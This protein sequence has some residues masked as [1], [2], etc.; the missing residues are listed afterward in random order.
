MKTKIYVG[1]VFDLGP[2]RGH[3][4]LFEQAKK[5][6]DYVIV[7][8]NSDSFT[9]QYKKKRPVQDQFE[10][11]NAVMSCRYVDMAFIMERGEDQIHYISMISPN[12]ILHGEGWERDSLIKQLG[13]TKEFMAENNIELRYVPLIPEIS[14]TKIKEKVK[15]Q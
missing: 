2:H 5:M 14:S 12:Y 1:G 4:Y 15:L 10:R 7:A 3:I 11:L 6:A 8:V 9:E 13:I